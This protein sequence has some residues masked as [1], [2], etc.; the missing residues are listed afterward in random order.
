MGSVDNQQGIIIGLIVCAVIAIIAIIIYFIVN[1]ILKSPFSFPFFVYSFD[2]SGKREPKVEDL[3]DGFL[4]EGNFDDIESHKQYIDLVWKPECLS[5]I[6]KARALKKRREMQYQVCCSNESRAY[7]F[8]IVRQQT[9]YKQV[10]YV[11]T[12][13][14]VYQKIGTFECD[15]DYLKGRNDSLKEINYECTLRQY[16]SKSQRKLLTKDLKEQ[17]KVR[18]NYTCQICGKYMPDEVGL[19][20]D[21][22]VPVSKGGKSVP[23]N[24]QVL[25]SKCNGKKSNN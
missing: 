18:D 1:K 15:Y 20:I 11:R 16:H 17:I 14:K 4:I 24:L 2:I 6:D 13:Y 12:P 10:N 3:L 8:T 25:C 21:H 22:I 7:H 5:K 9:R 23:S 19:H